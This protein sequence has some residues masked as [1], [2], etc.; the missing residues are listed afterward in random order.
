MRVKNP[1]QRNGHPN[2]SPD[3]AWRAGRPATRGSV[4]HGVDVGKTAAQV[5]AFALLAESA[6]VNIVVRVAGDAGAGQFDPRFDR[7]AMAGNAG[8]FDMCAVK[9]EVGAVMVELPEAPITGVVALLAIAPQGLAVRI[10][11]AMA[12]HAFGLCI[13]ECRCLVTI[14]AIDDLVS[15]Q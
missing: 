12:G 14:L 7:C 15:A 10:V 13:L 2:T 11:I 1:R 9:L 6:F 3:H 8:R 4:P 5:T